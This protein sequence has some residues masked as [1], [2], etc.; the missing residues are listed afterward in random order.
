MAPA[1]RLGTASRHGRVSAGGGFLGCEGRSC[2]LSLTGSGSA[3][4]SLL[5][6]FIINLFI[7]SSTAVRKRKQGPILM[8]DFWKSHSTR[9]HTV[10]KFVRRVLCQE[11]DSIHKEQSWDILHYYIKIHIP[12]SLRLK[13]EKNPNTNICVCVGG[14]PQWHKVLSLLRNN[15]VTLH[16]RTFS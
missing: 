9:H 15:F 10:W 6:D 8:P 12:T 7:N 2:P 3:Q 13:S 16:L 4:L 14:A 5:D 11:T 1:G